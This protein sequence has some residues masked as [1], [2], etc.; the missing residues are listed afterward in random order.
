MEWFVLVFGISLIQDCVR[1]PTTMGPLLLLHHG[2]CLAGLAVARIAPGPENW[3]RLFPFF[4]CACTALEVGS[5][6]CN[7][8]WLRLLR[9]RQRS[10]LYLLS[11]TISNLVAVAC[12]SLWASSPLAPGLARA[13][14]LVATCVLVYLRQKE[15]WS[16]CG[17]SRKHWLGKAG[18]E[19]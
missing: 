14:S 18:P 19:D 16:L 9:P 3:V 5:G 13:F 6:F 15:A 17:V 4:F 10:L 7:V 2:A 8:Y 1:F 11:M 12:S